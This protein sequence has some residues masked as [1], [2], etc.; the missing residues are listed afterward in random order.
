SQRFSRRAPGAIVLLLLAVA[1]LG[2]CLPE[3]RALAVGSSVLAVLVLF[4]WALSLDAARRQMARVCTAKVVWGFALLA[5][6]I[7]SRFLAAHVLHSLDNKSKP[8]V[9][10][11]EDVPVRRTYAMTDAGQPVALFHFR[12]HSTAAEV[13][14][15]ID[16]HETDLTQII[17]LADPN[18]AANCH[19]W[20]FTGGRYGIRE[21]EV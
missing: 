7:A 2:Y 16:L 9:L 12:M 11:L 8:Q 13:K 6:M 3:S 4:A 15:F 21:A 5:S 17:R 14:Q 20:V 1:L 10:D 19:G 18:S